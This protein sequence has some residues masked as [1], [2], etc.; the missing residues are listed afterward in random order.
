MRLRIDIES[1]NVRNMSTIA[2]SPTAIAAAGIVA[3]GHAT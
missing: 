2:V 1:R 3:V